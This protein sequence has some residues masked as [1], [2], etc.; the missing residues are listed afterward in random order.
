MYMPARI[1]R[2][3]RSLVGEGIVAIACNDEEMPARC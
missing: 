2:S 3:D 1:G